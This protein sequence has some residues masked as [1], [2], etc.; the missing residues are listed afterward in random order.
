MPTPLFIPTAQAAFIAGLT[1]RQM[2]RVVDEHL[3]PEPLFEQQGNSRLF[4]RLGAAFA[5]FYFSTEDLLLAGARR[6]VLDELSARVDRL[7]VKDQV[8]MLT[9]LDSMSWKVE[10]KHVEVDVLPFLQ[11]AFYRAKEVDQADAL[12]TTNP[13]VMGGVPVFVGTRVPFG[14]VLGSLA[15]GVHLGRL[16]ASYPF[17][18]EAH[19]QAAKVYE[20]VHPRRGRPRRIADVNPEL[21]R[22]V[23][24]VIK[25]A[26]SA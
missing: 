17:L 8:L 5:K 12:V 24:R 13:E 23:I 10:R 15:A 26:A 22:R 11:E 3:V 7:Q 18:T 4:T 16:Q 9:L 25:R 21:E 2:N 20:A 14:I 19:I 1:D 6:Q